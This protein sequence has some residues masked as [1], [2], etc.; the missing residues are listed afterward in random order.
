MSAHAVRLDALDHEGQTVCTINV[1]RHFSMWPLSWS[2]ACGAEGF[3]VVL[4]TTLAL[5]ECV[6]CRK[7]VARAEILAVCRAG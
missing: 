6:E 2:A 1:V 4:D 7:V 3:G 5:V